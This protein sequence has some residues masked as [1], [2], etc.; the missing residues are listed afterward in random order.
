M[1][2]YYMD[3]VFYAGEACV[4]CPKGTYADKGE[5][6]LDNMLIILRCYGYRAVKLYRL[7]RVRTL[8]N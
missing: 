2:H 5:Q 4:D 3:H 7:F 1:V 8:S 6:Y